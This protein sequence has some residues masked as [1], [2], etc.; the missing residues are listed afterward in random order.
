VAVEGKGARADPDGGGKGG[1]S[2][3]S[4]GVTAEVLQPAFR[5]S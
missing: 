3:T 4:V 5:E 2:A 1:Q